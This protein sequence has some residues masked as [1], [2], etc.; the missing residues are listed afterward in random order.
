MQT[1][2]DRAAQVPL[3]NLANIITMVRIALVPVFVLLMVPESTAARLAALA[4]FVGA[5]ATDKLDG[6]I[7]R[8]RGLRS[9]EHT[10][11]LQSRGHLVCRLLLE[12]KKN[13]HT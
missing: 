10:S 9:E 12:K 6:H 2:N 8:S 5:A 4:V 3:W 7:A 11:E 1:E 13:L